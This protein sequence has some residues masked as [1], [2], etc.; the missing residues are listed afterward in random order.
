MAE[1]STRTNPAANEIV[2]PNYGHNYVIENEVRAV[3]EKRDNNSTPSNEMKRNEQKHTTTENNKST[4]IRLSV[5]INRMWPIRRMKNT[6]KF[7]VRNEHVSHC[8]RGSLAH[9]PIYL[10]LHRYE[11]QVI[12]EFEFYF[13]IPFRIL[14]VRIRTYIAPQMNISGISKQILHHGHHGRRAH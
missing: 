3:N 5:C 1:R 13:G 11:K 2:R 9:A 10:L 8:V 12:F 6:M 4:H 14:Y 7:V